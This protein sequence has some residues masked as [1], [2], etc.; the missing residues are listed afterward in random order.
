MP[1]LQLL[2]DSFLGIFQLFVLL[3][4]FIG[5]AVVSDILMESITMIT[6]KTE[7]VEVRTI[8]GKSMMVSVPIWNPRI[9]YL[10]LMAIG[11]ALPEIFLCFM[12]SFTN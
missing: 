10:S 4:F 7:D 6:S 5:I 11:G 1:G 12:S 9:V 2:G 3:Y 8:D